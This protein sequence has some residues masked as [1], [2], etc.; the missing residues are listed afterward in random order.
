MSQSD[1][2]AHKNAISSICIVPSNHESTSLAQPFTNQE[3]FTGSLDSS[4]KHWNFTQSLHLNTP[5]YTNLNGPQQKFD[6][7]FNEIQ[8]NGRASKRVKVNS[9]VYYQNYDLLISGGTDRFINIYENASSNA[10]SYDQKRYRCCSKI[11][12]GGVSSVINKMCAIDGDKL[13]VG[14]SDE[15]INLYSIARV[16]SSQDGPSL[17]SSEP[18]ASYSFEESAINNLCALNEQNMFISS[19]LNRSISVWDT[20]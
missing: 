9:L 17:Q 1:Q 2:M 6:Y 10:S 13:I 18:I 5:S 16:G 8:Q 20:R 14:Q 4:I 19:A 11:A 7:K 12:K 3:I 15:K